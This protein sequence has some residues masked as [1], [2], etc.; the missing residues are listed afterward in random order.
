VT[1]AYEL[2]ILSYSSLVNVLSLLC[3]SSRSNP[4]AH[5][6]GRPSE[7]TTLIFSNRW[8]EA[9]TRSGVEKR[10]AHAVQQAVRQCPS[11]KGRT[12]SPHT[13]RHACAMHLLQADVDITLIA[14]F[15]GHESPCTTHHYIE[16][17]MK[18]KEQCLKKL[19]DLKT[20]AARFHPSDRLLEFLEKL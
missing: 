1:Q 5:L 9:L 13:F 2:Q 3:P 18:L 15:L 11:L 4:Q 14:L 16:L 10:L 17:D 8:G 19:P 20:K 7:P 12:I 6:A